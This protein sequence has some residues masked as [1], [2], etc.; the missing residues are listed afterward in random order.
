MGLEKIKELTYMVLDTDG[1]LLLELPV[2]SV[3]QVIGILIGI[4]AAIQ[5]IGCFFDY[6]EEEKNI[7]V[8]KRQRKR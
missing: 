8:Y 4:V 3:L 7:D 2:F 5:L 1:E 6:M